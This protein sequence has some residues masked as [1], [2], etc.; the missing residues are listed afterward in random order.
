MTLPHSHRA[1][2]L[3]IVGGA[4]R[5]GKQPAPTDTPALTVLVANDGREKTRLLDALA[6]GGT[7]DDLH[8]TRKSRGTSDTA[9]ESAGVNGRP[10]GNGSPPHPARKPADALLA[11]RLRLAAVRAEAAELGAEAEGK[12]PPDPKRALQLV[13]EA[14]EYR[15][16][17]LQLAAT[18]AQI[19]A[20]EQTIAACEHRLAAFGAAADT[21]WEEA[22]VPADELA[23]WQACI[24]GARA[25][26]A[27]A[28]QHATE[29]SAQA[30]SLGARANEE[31]ARDTDDEAP[32]IDARW[33]QLWRLRRELEEIWEV[34]SRAE[35][36]ARALV[37][38]EALLRAAESR[39]HWLPSRRLLR[40]SG[41]AALAGTLI[42]LWSGLYLD[43]GLDARDGAVAMAL[44]VVQA[45][46][47]CWNRFA[48]RRADRQDDA[49]QRQ[50]MIMSEMR[51]RRDR[52]WSRA[53]RLT[54][55]IE[56]GADALGLPLPIAPDE[57]EA[58]EH[59]MA[60][61]LRAGGG[62]TPLTTLLVELLGAQE[63][64]EQAEARQAA[65]AAERAAI[66]RE[67]I[68]W[69]D[70]TGL[71]AKLDAAQIGDWLE[72]RRHLTDA[73]AAHGAET[74]RLAHLE[75]ETAAWEDEV[76]ALLAATGQ[77][78][79][80]ETCG[81]ALTAELTMLGR[82]I[83]ATQER[84][85]RR[86]HVGTELRAAEAAG[87]AAE[88]AATRNGVL[89][90]M[91]G[92][93]AAEN[94]AASARTARVL[95]IA[96]AIL[97]YATNGAYTDLRAAPSGGVLVVDERDHALPMTAIPDRAGR[98]C[99]QFLLRL[100]EALIAPPRL[101]VVDDALAGLDDDEAATVAR[102]IAALAT[103]R[104]L[105]YVAS[106]TTR[107]RALRLLPGTARVLE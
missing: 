107:A 72:M 63:L 29:A 25:A 46:L 20:F 11:A 17:L 49:Q 44:I 31:L 50:R 65:A 85:R 12:L 82:R 71:P 37:E 84:E 61:E 53:A 23:E 90:R 102:A 26:E 77:S 22:A 95:E 8:A 106:T 14:P 42:A 5:A 55:T 105:V 16:R 74:G 79:A 15:T 97:S 27:T 34:Q 66:E 58:C 62:D 94:G 30:R 59:A 13:R 78:V 24:A 28:V 41:L 40:F 93:A 99:L 3:R 19:A 87:A 9:G 48:G 104:P 73:R 103:T 91:A 83:R 69:R 68:A 96:G 7:P 35:E 21:S 33:R 81:R 45:V 43:G 57:L 67:W 64:A 101:L 52:D 88:A 76:R 75:P 6:Q 100:G 60:D 54:T 89:S 4:P 56:V 70:A 2:S 98:R 10:G 36:E 86:E 80:A 92:A 18:R 51:R 32:E 47:L 1:R 39:A 38:R